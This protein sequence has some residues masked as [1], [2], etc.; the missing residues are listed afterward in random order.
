MPS[1]F[2]DP[3]ALPTMTFDWGVIKPLVATDNTE[4]P[5][6]SLMHVILLPGKGHE[7]HNHPESDENLYILAGEGDQMVDDEEPRGVRP[8]DTVFIPKGAFHST[9]NTGYEPMV[10]LAIY[11][12]AGAEE[13]LKTLPDYQE[14]PAGQAPALSR[15]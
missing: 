2:V 1:K 6:V 9:L 8:G 7:R 4:D 3:S 5:A 13:V 11:A 10:I 12:P 14:I 15:G